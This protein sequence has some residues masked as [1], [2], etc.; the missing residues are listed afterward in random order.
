MSEKHCVCISQC[1]APVALCAL[2]LCI[3]IALR[4]CSVHEWRDK[5]GKREATY[6]AVFT[7]K[8]ERR[9]M[10]LLMKMMRVMVCVDAMGVVV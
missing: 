3:E 7:S 6:S 5:R 1:D 10:M 8:K 2:V 4:G 9:L